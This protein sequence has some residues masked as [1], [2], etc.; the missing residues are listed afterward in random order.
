MI[1][2]GFLPDCFQ[3]IIFIKKLYI[4]QFNSLRWISPNFLMAKI[5]ILAK[6]VTE[7][8]ISIILWGSLGNAVMIISTLCFG[9][10]IGFYYGYEADIN[11]TV[12]ILQ[13]VFSDFV[14]KWK[15]KSFKL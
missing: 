5:L 12:S 4:Y 8:F 6:K 7:E 15:L 11:N 3:I 2:Y 13:R 1:E 14:E 9:V 10:D